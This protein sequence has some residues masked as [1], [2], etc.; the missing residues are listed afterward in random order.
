MK[1]PITYYGGKQTMLKHILPLIPQ[2]TIYTECF[3]G[4]AALFFAKRPAIT[5]VINDLNGELVNFYRTIVSDFDA[6]RAEIER[7]IHS[8]FQHEVAWFIYNHSDYFTNVQRAWA[9]WV[10]SKLG[11]AGQMSSSFGF[12]FEGRQPRKIGN[13]KE[14]FTDELR[15]RLANTTIERDDAYNVIR[16]Y[17]TPNTFHFIDPPYV[18]TN[19]AHYA[20]MFD[21]ADLER[22]LQLCEKLTGKFMLTMFPNDVIKDYAD[23][24]GW[25][26]HSIERHITACRDNRRRQEEWMVCN[27][28]QPMQ[29]QS[30]DLFQD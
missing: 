13:A 4:G 29:Q 19:S 18:S 20:D 27:Y 8:R 14:Q 12:D 23:K 10:L 21:D 28:V 2:H 15:Q 7:T 1:T 3:A 24:N 30:L 17:D 5:D 11:F 25:I 6:L 22:L 26:I 16:R 9:V